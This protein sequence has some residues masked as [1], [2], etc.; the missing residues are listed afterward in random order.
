[1][2][3]RRHPGHQPTSTAPFGGRPPASFD[4]VGCPSSVGQSGGDCAPWPPGS[5]LVQL[6]VCRHGRI[7]G[8]H[9]PTSLAGPRA[10][11]GFVTSHRRPARVPGFSTRRGGFPRVDLTGQPYVI[12]VPIGCL[13]RG[14]RPDIRPY[15]HDAVT[16]ASG[17]ERRRIGQAD[18]GSRGGV[19]YPLDHSRDLRLIHGQAAHTPNW[20]PRPASRLHG[21]PSKYQPRRDTCSGYPNAMQRSHTVDRETT[22]GPGHHPGPADNVVHPQQKNV[23]SSL[24]MS[25]PYAWRRGEPRTC[26][27]KERTWKPLSYLLTTQSSRTASST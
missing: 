8:E 20:E 26:A 17:Q 12:P 15:S 10:P 23:R 11:P 5:A 1:M 7:N 22:A 18:R 2:A 25:G 13:W 14:A 9:N 4:C 27:S 6:V 24:P 19:Y 16:A 21:Q 3:P